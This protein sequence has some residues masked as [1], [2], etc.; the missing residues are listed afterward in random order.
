MAE[1]LQAIATEA[2]ALDAELAPVQPDSQATPEAEAGVEPVPLADPRESLAGLLSVLGIAAG[3]AGF[4]KTAAIWTPDTCRGLADKAVPV[5]VK[6]AWG[7]RLMNFLATGAGVEEM[8]LIAFAA[9]LVLA[10]VGAVKDD[11]K[12]EDKPAPAPAQ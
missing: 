12:P 2:A 3:Y 5:L 4:P 8:A 9:P 7:Q 11:L 6:Y 10:T 1:E